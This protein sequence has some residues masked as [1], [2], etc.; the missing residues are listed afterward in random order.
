MKQQLFTNWHPMR[1]IALVLGLALGLIWLA[2]NAPV[3]G[4]LSLFLLF[5]A[6][7]NT[8]CIAGQCTPGM[9]NDYDK[10]RPGETEYEEIT[11]KK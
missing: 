6:I 4:F 5:Q 1:W 9:K 11:T 2:N 7:T 10:E 3:S 8:G